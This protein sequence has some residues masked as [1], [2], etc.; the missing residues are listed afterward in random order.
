MI[1][2]YSI[3]DDKILNL[4]LKRLQNKAKKLI[5][6]D[7]YDHIRLSNLQYSIL[8]QIT[9][10]KKHDD[11]N[12]YLWNT[13]LLEKTLKDIENKIKEEKNLGVKKWKKEI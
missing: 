11:I 3:E 12:V 9:N 2:K 7:Y 8:K 5:L 6:N 1:S 10:A 4:E 13:G